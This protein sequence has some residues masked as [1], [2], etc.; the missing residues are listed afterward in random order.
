VL[1]I[2]LPGCKTVTALTETCRDVLEIDSVETV[3]SGSVGT[4][5]IDILSTRLVAAASPLA[6]LPADVM[7]S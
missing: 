1:S 4:A 7:S 3:S 5:S 2:E 6:D